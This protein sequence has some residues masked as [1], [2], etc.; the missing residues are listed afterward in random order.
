MTLPPDSVPLI[1][2]TDFGLSRFIELAPDGTGELLSTR[3]GSEAYAAPEL[4]MGGTRVVRVS[5][6]STNRPR[7]WRGV[8]DGRETDAWAC[9]VVL[10]VLLGRVLPFGEGVSVDGVKRNR[11]GGERAIGG[12]SAAERRQWLMRIAKGE[13]TWPE[14]EQGGEEISSVDVHVVIGENGT[15]KVTGASG[16]LQTE[17]QTSDNEA[18]TEEEE[19]CGATLIRSAGA[20]RIVTRLLVRNPKKRAG[21]ADLWDDSW[22]GGE[23]NEGVDWD[24]P[25]PATGYDGA[26]V[27][28]EDAAQIPVELNFDLHKDR[29]WRDA[30]GQ[31]DLFDSDDEVEGWEGMSGDEFEG[32]EEDCSAAD[33]FEDEDGWLLDQDGIDNIARQEVV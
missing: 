7:E 11:I 19:L 13:W 16:S 28:G 2:L 31:R 1:K 14:E 5:G 21:I 15:T 20:R 25:L 17:A 29:R 27:S 30:R 26:G 23:E 22:M 24:T 6:E 32:D 4:V 3:C 8:Y 10:Y 9:G 12:T 18:A 33:G